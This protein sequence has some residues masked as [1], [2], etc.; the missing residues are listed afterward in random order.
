MSAGAPPSGST[1]PSPRT[2]RA[3]VRATARRA[4]RRRTG[5][6]DAR[7]F[8][9]ASG[10][11][12]PARGRTILGTALRR[13][14]AGTSGGELQEGRVRPNADPVDH[15][16]PGRARRFHWDLRHRLGP[17]RWREWDL[18]RAPR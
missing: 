7:A 17:T 4:E 9:A 15:R 3:D 10:L 16:I 13:A 12:D 5:P 2:R 8:Q 18:H 11:G 14:D 6:L 1:R